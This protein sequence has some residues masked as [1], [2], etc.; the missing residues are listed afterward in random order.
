MTTKVA[1]PRPTEIQTTAFHEAGHCI[2]GIQVGWI[3][4]AT[5]E[6]GQGGPGS[7]G[8]TVR[9]SR[10][11]SHFPQ[12]RLK[13]PKSRRAEVERRLRREA[14]A[15]V[16][17]S[18]AGLA[19]EEILLGAPRFGAA[20]PPWGEPWLSDLH[21]LRSGVELEAGY[22]AAVAEEYL[23]AAYPRLPGL[24]KWTP[25]AV[26]MKRLRAQY[27]QT[28]AYLRVHWLNVAAVARALLKEKRLDTK[29]IYDVAYSVGDIAFLSGPPTL[30]RTT[31]KKE[32]S[33]GS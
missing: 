6:Q 21:W 18:L 11:A 17:C 33:H 30:A 29:R 28:I 23:R 8:A 15:E 14:L 20:S 1:R 26:G 31:T 3:E 4:F 5:I 27:A 12:L 16:R 24:D 22:D 13:T 32:G 19:A 10:P 2:A 25:E 7:A 9:H